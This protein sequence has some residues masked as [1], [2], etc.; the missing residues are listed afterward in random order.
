MAGVSPATADRAA[1]DPVAHSCVLKL[2]RCSFLM[3][4]E[5]AFQPD[6]MGPRPSG[7]RSQTRYIPAP[8]YI[9]PALGAA[10]PLSKCNKGADPAGWGLYS[11]NKAAIA[12]HFCFPVSRSLS[13]LHAQVL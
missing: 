12:R 11:P 2:L 4:N 9:A 7:A 3:R 13:T 5:S 6:I 10:R 8:D 1:F